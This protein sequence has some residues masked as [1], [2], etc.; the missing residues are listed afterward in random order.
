M[1]LRKHLRRCVFIW[2]I[3]ALT[4]LA[5]GAAADEVVANGIFQG[6]RTTGSAQIV[7]TADGW[8]VRLGNDFR[9]EG[10]PDPWV[11]LGQGGFRRDAQLGPLRSDE[12]AQLYPI[13][14][15]LNPAEFDAVYIWCQQYATSL[16][17]ALLVPAD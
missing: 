1:V 17:R 14:E 8:A 11:A 9:H 15:R 2:Q 13:P 4:L 7:R 6:G 12:G 10:A 16:G 3:L 5:R